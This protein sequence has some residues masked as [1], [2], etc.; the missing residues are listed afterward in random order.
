M[1]T[2]ILNF[3]LCSA[4]LLTASRIALMVWQRD[5]VVS[6]NG[7]G[8]ILLGGLRIDALL[9][10]LAVAPLLLV[11]P[12]LAGSDDAA[13]VS[14]AW[15]VAAWALICLLELS[16]PL[17]IVEYD[18]RPNRLYVD[19]LKHPQEVFG[20]IWKG[21]KFTAIAVVLSLG[22]FIVL[23][24]EAF[25]EESTPGFRVPGVLLQIGVLLGSAALAFLAIRGTLR[26]RPINP[27]T[28]AFC[29]DPLMNTLALNS[30]YNVLYAVYSMKNE[31]SPADAYGK[32]PPQEILDTV[33]TSARM[34]LAAAV[35]PRIPTLHCHV[36]TVAA[37]GGTRPRN[38]VLIV[39][40][41]LGA[42][43]TGH[44]G[45]LDLTPNLDALSRQAW[46]FTRAYATGTRSVR[47]LEALVAGFPPSL[48]DAVLR[49]PDAQSRFFTLAHLLRGR[50][51]RSRFIYGGEAHFDNMKSFFLGNGFDDLHDR[52]TF[53][54]PA[55]VGTWGVSDEDMFTRL[56]ELLDGPS[57][58]PT[59]TL[60][61]SVTNHSPWEYP[62]GRITPQGEP[63]SVDNTVRY[64]D[65]ALG[66]FF[67][68]AQKCDYWKDTIFLVAADHEARVG[69]QQRIPLR[70]F[71]IPALILGGAVQPRQDDRIVSQIDLPV[72]LLS[73]LGIETEHPMIGHDLTAPDA[74]G[75]AMMQ[76]GE[77]FGYLKGRD[78]L[79]LEPQRPPTQ[80]RY[81]A[82]EHYDAVAVDEA[83]RR[84]ALAHALWPDLAYRSRAYTLPGLLLE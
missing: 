48:S 4:L 67:E 41:S 55:F 8:P 51:Y 34:N 44:L 45:G 59:L 5:R 12:W 56:H 24:Y 37:H 73:L 65:W 83:L 28:V 76:Y 49:L 79:V 72:T 43:Y 6:V 1:Y 22:G 29:G 10:A 31:R 70:Y 69:G 81:E 77:N 50:G 63:A 68:R 84:E 38:V 71:H 30:L 21:Y 52:K 47:G 75:R 27:S 15:L 18:A 23:G 74:G 53:R 82:P 78:L 58:V 40:E 19:Y 2:Q 11:A 13:D 32:M 26:H 39:Q 61:F 16:S 80:W 54:N 14:G 25:G 66:Q 46:T 17:F 42:K 9:I 35:H 20:M 60:A 64:A 57:D 3:V 62:S 33:R 36:P 7:V